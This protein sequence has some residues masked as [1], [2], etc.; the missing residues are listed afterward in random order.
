[1]KTKCKENCSNALYSSIKRS[2]LKKLVKMFRHKTFFSTF[3]IRGRL[4]Q[5]QILQIEED[6]DLLENCRLVQI[7]EKKALLVLLIG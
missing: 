4:H 2:G 6:M 1:V 7:T 5:C 3:L